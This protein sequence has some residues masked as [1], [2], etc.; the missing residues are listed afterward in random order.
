MRLTKVASVHS[1]WIYETV[2]V[3]AILSARGSH[4]KSVLGIQ[5]VKVKYFAG[6]GVLTVHH[7]YE[8]YRPTGGLSASGRRDH[9]QLYARRT[10]RDPGG[11]YRGRR[12]LFL[13]IMRT[14]LPYGER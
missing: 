13:R 7:E 5:L 1:C 11:C 9:V 14:V 10:M 12:P 2:W 4:S 3:A 8:F 6:H